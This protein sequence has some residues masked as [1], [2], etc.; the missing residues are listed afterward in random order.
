[1]SQRLQ[2]KT[3]QHIHY[4][5]NKYVHLGLKKASL[6]LFCFVFVLGSTDWATSEVVGGGRWEELPHVQGAAAV[7]AQEGREKLLHVQGQE[8]RPWDDT[9]R[10]R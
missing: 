7:G 4:S 6:P 1:M 9:P 3:H 8:G 10:P 2:C 5:W